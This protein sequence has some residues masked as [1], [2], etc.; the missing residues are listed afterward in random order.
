MIAG[1][2]GHSF[3]T[4]SDDQLF[5][6]TSFVLD[7]PKVTGMTSKPWSFCQLQLRRAV[8]TLD[9]SSNAVRS[10]FSDWTAPAWVQLLPDFDLYSTNN[11]FANLTLSLA[12][13][14]FQLA[15]ANGT[16]L[17]SPP[18]AG[19]GDFQFGNYMA[20]THF[21]TDVTGIPTQEAY[22]GLYQPSGQN[23]V[24]VGSSITPIATAASGQPVSY[25]A[26]IITIQGRP[27][28]NT[29]P[30]F[31]SEDA[32]WESLLGSSIPDAQRMRIIGVSRPIDMKNSPHP[33]C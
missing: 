26:R 4:V 3:D 25:R 16:I 12:N 6:N 33:G 8:Y 2:V 29:L 13:N 14:N 23:W 30:T 7:Y 15:E 19:T 17:S 9:A 28:A 18:T 27:T 32:F 21:V 24:P 5:V 10:A 11:R 22:D 31:P 20:V 1:P